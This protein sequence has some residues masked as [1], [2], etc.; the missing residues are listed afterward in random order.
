[1]P[2]C[3]EQLKDYLKGLLQ[4]HREKAQAHRTSLGWSA[5]LVVPWIQIGTYL[6]NGNAQPSNFSAINPATS[7]ATLAQG[8]V[9]PLTIQLISGVQG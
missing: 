5:A 6:V 7:S 8:R 2:T 1:M 9:D 4:L 3:H